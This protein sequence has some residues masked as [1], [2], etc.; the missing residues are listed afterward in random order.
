[1]TSPEFRAGLLR[2]AELRCKRCANGEAATFHAGYWRHMRET[3]TTT[4]GLEMC[5]GWIECDAGDIRAEAAAI[6]DEPTTVEIA[7]PG[8]HTIISSPQAPLR[9]KDEPPPRNID[10][11]CA[12]LER[13][14]NQLRERNAR[15]VEA[16]DHI[17]WLSPEVI[18]GRPKVHASEIIARKA[19]REH[20][21]QRGAAALADENPTSPQQ[22]GAETIDA[23]A[24]HHSTGVAEMNWQLL[25]KAPMYILGRD[26]LVGQYV[27]GWGW[28]KVTIWEREWTRDECIHRGATHWW[29]HLRNLPEP[30]RSTASV[31]TALSPESVGQGD[32]RR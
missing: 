31:S 13:T 2:A 15:L 22:I 17:V 23:A 18:N 24:P 30:Q 16:L 1:M 3:I 8:K 12:G 28:K 4:S 26:A 9:F 25:E 21:Q 32:A 20:D 14:V 7:P 29:P 10:N 5:E 11:Y 19:L 6:K 27:P